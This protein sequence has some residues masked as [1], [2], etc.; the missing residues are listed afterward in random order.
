MS[1]SVQ[2]INH[3]MMTSLG[4]IGYYQKASALFLERGRGRLSLVG[5]DSTLSLDKCLEVVVWLWRI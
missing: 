1:L 5:A 2:L 3:K 4:V